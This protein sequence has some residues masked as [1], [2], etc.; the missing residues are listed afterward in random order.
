MSALDPEQIALLIRGQ[1]A[2]RTALPRHVRHQRTL[3]VNNDAAVKRERAELV[4]LLA[5]CYGD[6]DDARR[7]LEQQMAKGLDVAT[8]VRHLEMSPSRFG[9]FRGAEAGNIYAYLPDRE[10]L[11]AALTRAAGALDVARERAAALIPVDAAP[12]RRRRAAPDHAEM[13]S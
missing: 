6:P 10:R 11:M 7:K 4:R 9:A 13:T 3:R 12:V 8:L 5:C 1:M 2:R